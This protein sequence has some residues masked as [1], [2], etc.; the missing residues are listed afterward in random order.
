MRRAVVLAFAGLGVAVGA[1][2]LGVAH[3]APASSFAGRSTGGAFALLGGGLVLIACGLICSLRLA[4]NRVGPLLAGA[5]VAW[6][7]LEWNNP[8]VGSALAFTVGLCLYAACPP[9]VAHAVLVYPRGRLRTGV[10]RIVLA[11][12]YAGSVLVLGLLPA[13]FFDPVAEGCG[14]CPRNLLLVAG[15]ERAKADL[16]RVGVYLATA[17]ALALVVLVLA[18][19]VRAN[20]RSRPV[21]VV[22]AAYL[23]L[24]AAMFAASRQRGFLW[25]GTLERRL[26]FVQAAALACVAAGVTWGWL[27]GRRARSAV[28][29]LV[30]D[31]AHTPP[32][33]GLRDVL[34]A[35][36]GDREL[37]L[38][39]P[40]ADSGRLVDADGRAVEL[41]ASPARTSLV[42]DGRIV[43]VLAHARGLLDDEQL[44]DEVTAAARLALEN[45]RLQAE[46]RARLTDLRASRTRIVETSDSERRRIERN[47]HD[48]AQQRLVAL[49]LRLRLLRSQLSPLAGAGA[50]ARLE[51]T[52]AE[53]DSAI[54]ELRELAHGIFP[55]VLADGGLAVAV[56]ALAEDAAVPIRIGPLPEGRFLP[57]VETAAY[58]V[59]A[60]AAQ[61]ATG[62]LRITALTRDGSLVVEVEMQADGRTLDRVALEDRL[63]ALDGRLS[64]DQAQDG[65]VTIR[66]ELP[67]GS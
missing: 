42:R 26:W 47:L 9:L 53:L 65:R 46:V 17:W 43:A 58:T 63:G 36:L 52:E 48:G 2:S 54:A 8:G 40:L 38:A 19:L 5:G 4:A 60:E 7:L 55:A 34:A 33:G 57:A 10:E 61:V 20:G 35:I 50:R 37:V 30:V 44:V 14:Q 59:V 31:L 27:A 18:R 3:D 1:Y 11:A 51:L 66:A 22:G 16:Y 25:N 62:P 23:G 6:F 32:P 45:E 41:A 56:R 39:Y 24:V 13:F 64:I 28:A 49:S 12:A 29:R 67:C 21:L 15:R